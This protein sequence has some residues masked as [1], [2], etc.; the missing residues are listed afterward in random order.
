MNLNSLSNTQLFASFENLVRSER[1]VTAQVLECIAE[2]DRRKIYLE[3]NFTSLFDYLVKD[4]GYSPGAAMRRIDAA[5]LLEK[6]NKSVG[7]VLTD[8]KIG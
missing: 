7:H 2:I 8:G 1:K 5:R 4:L 3:K 6:R